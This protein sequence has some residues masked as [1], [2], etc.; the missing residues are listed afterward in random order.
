MLT[1]EKLDKIEK[2]KELEKIETRGYQN[3]FRP[4]TSEIKLSLLTLLLGFLFIRW[5]FFAF[6]GVGVFLFS[7]LFSI[8]AIS[9]LRKEESFDVK[10]AQA[11]FG[12]TIALGMSYATFDNAML[13]PF[14][15]IILIFT[16][17]YAVLASS[18]NRVKNELGNWL[19]IDLIY[20]L[21]IM[22]FSNFSLEFKAIYAMRTKG[23]GE[24][25]RMTSIAMGML[26]TGFILVLVLP[27]LISADTGGFSEL[28][29][30][31]NHW[32]F[33]NEEA[34]T[35]NVFSLIFG[36]PVSAYFYGLFIGCKNS[37]GLG[38]DRE[39]RLSVQYEKYRF[40]QPLSAKIVLGFMMA[41]Y[42]VFILTQ[43][44]FYISA[45]NG[46]LPEES[47]S[48]AA[49]AR[50][51]FFELIKVAFINVIMLAT[52]AALSRKKAYVKRD[53]V[54]LR[55]LGIGISIITLFL[56]LTA[57]S[58]MYLYISVYGL[59]L[60]RLMPCMFMIWM[61]L[62]LL[63][64]M[65]RPHYCIR[66]S[67]ILGAIAF[68]LI[69]NAN[70]SGFVVDYNANRF[71]EGTLNQFD[72]SVLSQSG[73]SGIVTAERLLAQ[74][75]KFASDPHL[76]ANIEEYLWSQSQYLNAEKWTFQDTLGNWRGRQI[77]LTLDDN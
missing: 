23:Q 62:A 35:E 26:M 32:S 50:N 3:P 53:Q 20:A 4:N 38:L 11:W 25:N 27:L 76:I 46:I 42:L 67:L 13:L 12:F 19:V 54:E 40:I 75:E 71:L 1:Q 15:N 56:I 22:P 9:T 8:I 31:M 10:S 74:K 72:L 17:A 55:I 29:K 60:R 73:S 77:L 7:L 18:G 28:F 48:Y 37:E 14:K 58:K 39:R 65:F 43:L 47:S 51:G 64:W 66:E 24:Y 57:F 33:W 34:F 2:I 41:L 52:G 36:I 44:P 59:T 70:I 61:A 63:L 68:I 5:V 16:A 45:M 30:W 49:Y 6:K 21:G 69:S